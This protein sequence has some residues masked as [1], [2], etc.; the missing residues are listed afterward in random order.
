MFKTE[1]YRRA[2]L[3]EFADVLRQLDE[4]LQ[5]AG[6]PAE[7]FRAVHTLKASAGT[8][9]HEAVQSLCHH[10]ETAYDEVLQGVAVVEPGLRQVTETA[11]EALRAWQRDYEQQPAH[12][13][14][15]A[16]TIHGCFLEYA[17]FVAEWA[18]RHSLLVELDVVGVD[19]VL[20]ET[21][22]R[23]WSEVLLQLL[24]NAL[25]HGLEPPAERVVAGKRPVAQ[26]T[27]TVTAT[28]ADECVTFADDGRGVDPQLLPQRLFELGASAAPAVSLAAGRGIGLDLV[29]TR[30]REIGYTIAVTSER[31]HGTNFRMQ[32]ATVESRVDFV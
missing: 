10:L 17:P 20:H 23:V 1:R 27:L 5:G 14:D 25:V 31:Q 2:Y 6:S 19:R 8:M 29:R 13:Q 18:Q 3:A 15:A 21:Q 7:L 32:R 11:V 22:A 12:N 28:D 9:G 16:T 30:L 24:L 26:V 4:Q